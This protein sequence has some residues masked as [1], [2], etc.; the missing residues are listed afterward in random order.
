[1]SIV[2]FQ[3]DCRDVLATLPDNSIH[4]CVTSPR[5]SDGRFRKG[6][7]AYRTPKP[8]WEGA[9][10]F[11][12]Y[13]EY[14]RSTG[15][16]ARDIGCTDANVLFWLKKHGIERRSVSQARTIKHWGSKGEANPMHGKTG[17]ANP[18]FVDGS[19]PERQRLY[20]QGVG[21]A[22]LRAILERD[23]YRCTRCNA[24]KIGQRGLHV[25]HLK[26]WAGN[27][28]LRF[29]PSNVVTLCRSCHSWVHSKA[30]IARELLQ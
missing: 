20:A 16:I 26:A 24:P 18:R 30:N 1:M 12:E 3:G 19:S 14:A 5:A 9:W 13:V 29:D 27:A 4:C 15:D 21:K 11:R 25:H 17:E 2:I 7:H 6:S 10:L 22:F 8:H 28:S 23:S